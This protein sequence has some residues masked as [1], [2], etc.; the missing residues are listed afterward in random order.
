[1]KHRLTIAAFAC[2]IL[3]T[4]LVIVDVVISRRNKERLSAVQTTFRI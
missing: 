2:D 4:I 3:G 1:M